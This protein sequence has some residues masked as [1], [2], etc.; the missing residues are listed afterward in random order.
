MAKPRKSRKGLSGR[1][2]GLL[3][4]AIALALVLQLLIPR[5]HEPYP[6]ILLPA[7]GSLIRAGQDTIIFRKYTVEAIHPGGNRSVISSAELLPFLASPVARR[8]VLFHRF[9]QFDTGLSDREIKV[10]LGSMM[11]TLR[12]MKATPEEVLATRRWLLRRAEKI[13]HQPV[14][15]LILSDNM[16]GLSIRS[17]KTF[18]IRALNRYADGFEFITNDASN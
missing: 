4:P 3:F 7:G 5:S 6:A 1:T 15:S 2:L 18:H 13:T 12:K 10:Q 17:A 16:V 9:Q 8:N 11:I 14:D